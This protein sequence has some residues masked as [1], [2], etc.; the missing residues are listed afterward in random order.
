MLLSHFPE[1]IVETYNLEALAVDGWVYIEIRKDMYGLKQAGLL[2]NKLL[3]KRLAHF[4]Y[5]PARHTPGLWLHKSQPIAFSLIVDDFA[6][7]YVGKHHADHLINTL[8]QR[9]EL[10]TDWEAKVYSGNGITKTEHVTFLFLVTFPMYSSNFNM[11]PLSIR[12]THKP[13]M[14]RRCMGQKPNMQLKMRHPPS[15]PNSV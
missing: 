7:K 15:L 4:G 5:Y 12:N 13:N 14:P 11:M 6:A 3:Q 8:L 10:T 2:A 1:E 9:Y